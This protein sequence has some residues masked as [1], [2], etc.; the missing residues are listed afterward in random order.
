MALYGGTS[1]VLRIN[2]YCSSCDLCKTLQF[3]LLLSI[4]KETTVSANG[5]FLYSEYCNCPKKYVIEWMKENGCKKRH[6]QLVKDLKQWSVID[7]TKVIGIVR[8]KWTD[9][10][11]RYSVAICHYQIIDNE[12]SCKLI[13]SIIIIWT[14]FVDSQSTMLERNVHVQLLRKCYG[15]HTGFRMFVDEILTSLLRKMKLPN[16][17]M[18]VN[19]GDWPLART[20]DG[21][22]PIV[23]WCGS[24]GKGGI[25]MSKF[26]AWLTQI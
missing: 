25:F 18:I 15:A 7:F 17:E 13:S 9:N 21:P 19:L 1:C 16:T 2:I 5:D 8:K 20:S 22:L 11:H 6:K 12:V 24:K 4:N 23:S 14:S 10:I 3:S 26:F